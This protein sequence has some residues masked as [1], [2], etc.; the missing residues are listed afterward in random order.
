MAIEVQIHICTVSIRFVY[1]H[2]TLGMQSYNVL[3]PPVP[4]CR[5]LLSQ[6]I[7]F[8]FPKKLIMFPFFGAA[9]PLLPFWLAF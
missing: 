3:S 9:L 5:T 8:F 6:S 7:Q 4:S 2:S 1:L